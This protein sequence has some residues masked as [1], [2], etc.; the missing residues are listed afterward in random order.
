MRIPQR[1]SKDGS[2]EVYI[3]Y[4]EDKIPHSTQ[5]QHDKGNRER[6]NVKTGS[7][8]VSPDTDSL[9]T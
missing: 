1:H 5:R 9:P 4:I 7:K 3:G 6:R 2:S 8:N